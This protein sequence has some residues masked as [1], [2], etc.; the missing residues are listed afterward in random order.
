[1]VQ[2]RDA[3]PAQVLSDLFEVA[4]GERDRMAHAAVGGEIL[5]G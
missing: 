1:L 3:D 5:T 2:D 4:D